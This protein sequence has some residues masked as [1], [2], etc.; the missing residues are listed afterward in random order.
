MSLYGQNNGALTLALPSGY[1]STKDV[2]FYVRFRRPAA[3]DN[4]D[5]LLTFIGNAGAQGFI[6]A[7]GGGVSWNGV[8][9]DLWLATGPGGT[10][11][12][13]Y[14]CRNSS[15]YNRRYYANAL[16]LDTWTG[17]AASIKGTAA[18]DNTSG[19]TG[20]Q[21]IASF[22]LAGS[23][24]S[25]TNDSTNSTTNGFGGGTTNGLSLCGRVN[26]TSSYASL[27][28][29][30]L[31]VWQDY[32]LTQSD[33]DAIEAG[34]DPS[35]IQPSKVLYFN[36]LRSSLAA[37]IGNTSTIYTNG[38]APTIASG[39]NPPG[40]SGL[41]G[42][43]QAQATAT[44][45]LQ[46]AINL[47]GNAQAQASASGSFDTAPIVLGGNAQAQASASGELE[48]QIVLGGNATAQ[49]DASASFFGFTAPTITR[50]ESG[51][52][53]VASCTI[54]NQTAQ[55]PIIN[56]AP[57]PE[58][59]D[60]AGTSWERFYAQ[61]DLKQTGRTPT[62]NLPFAQ[63]RSTTIPDVT[64][65]FWRYVGETRNDWKPFDNRL[66]TGSGTAGANLQVWN[67]APFAQKD[68]EFAFFPPFNYSDITDLLT[69][70]DGT[71]YAVEPNF[72]A[73]FKAANPSAP[74]YA[75]FDNLSVAGP[76]G[77]NPDPTWAFAIEITD[78]TLKPVDGTEKRKVFCD[79][80][81][82]GE[83]SG[84]WNMYQFLQFL[85]GSSVTAQNLRRNFRFV[86]LWV[87]TSGLFAGMAR[88]LCQP[89]EVGRDPNRV[90]WSDINDNTSGTGSASVVD[91]TCQAIKD[92]AGLT[93]DG[94]K[95]NCE[96]NLS[97]HS[98]YF[99][100]TDY[101]SD[102]S[103]SHAAPM[104]TY[105][106]RVRTEWTALGN[107]GTFQNNGNSSIA[108]RS[109]GFARLA[110][111]GK[112]YHT[113]EAGYALG[114][115][116]YTKT[117]QLAEANARAVDYLFAQG[118]LPGEAI[119]G[120]NAQAEATASGD[121]SSA[122]ASGDIAGSAQALASASAALETQ[123]ILE[124]N[125][126]GQASAS[127]NITT[128]IQLGGNATAQASASGNITTQIANPLTAPKA[129]TF[130]IER[131]DRTLKVSV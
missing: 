114:S 10:G 78:P 45:T 30:D 74:K 4:G 79:W 61:I 120:G 66:A 17:V 41:A 97:W 40:Y 106:S 42:N 73:A 70:L 85:R 130:I 3:A 111:K 110:C 98:S 103:T 8:N 53:N 89:G 24:S 15:G 62:F 38:T 39:V 21:Q 83:D 124:S 95:I 80:V 23:N 107:S 121:L 108:G 71:A 25:L 69:E 128:Q 32:R 50:P 119:L 123:I 49:A 94:T 59:N 67:N 65:C 127:G 57:Y 84:L 54:T 36:S 11:T 115:D 68:V 76:D 87:N 96:G 22:W 56:W 44:G 129:R 35:S 112:L 18:G 102:F 90:W 33:V 13:T 26:S 77:I 117:A 101:P 60:N 63:W 105:A 58:S 100:Y 88:G 37:E 9:T 91:A 2:S 6:L 28:V 16:A 125:A 64:S 7:F 31:C 14:G 109:P 86:F 47:A 131:P 93:V 99:N 48:T 27:Y 34:A 113:Q 55:N 72:C 92:W 20:A 126:S 118:L 12:G 51:D 104:T 5:R 82:A 81:H 116:F 46:T 122:A 75:Y 19:T 1:D 29:A 52:V 43:A